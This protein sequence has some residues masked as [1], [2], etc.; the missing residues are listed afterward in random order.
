MFH[1]ISATLAQVHAQVAS[2]S[3][4]P[5]PV[6]VTNFEDIP[7]DP[8]LLE[9]T[10]IAARA[11]VV[12]AIISFAA[13][14]VGSIELFIATRALVRRPRLLL[15]YQEGKTETWVAQQLLRVQAMPMNL[16]IQN[17]GN[18]TANSPLL[19]LLIPPGIIVT[20]RPPRQNFRDTISST[21]ESGKDYTQIDLPLDRPSY[22]K[23]E[24]LIESLQVEGA[25]A[26][27]QTLASLWRLACDDGT[28]PEEKAWGA[29]SVHVQA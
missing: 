5:A 12:A 22:P 21:R 28:F 29:L 9:W 2:A 25:Q 10:I 20:A 18:K 17:D 15:R 8:T 3:P 11:A 24:I 1:E 14:V 27:G 16:C 19:R 26:V 6:R 4:P 13:V 7:T 23:F